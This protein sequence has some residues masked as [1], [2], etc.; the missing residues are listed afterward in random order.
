[1]IS[2]TVSRLCHRAEDSNKYSFGHVL[3]VGG[4]PGM[5]GAP[6]LSATAAMRIGAGLVTIASSSN[7]I[8]KLEER[9]VEIMTLRIELSE[10]SSVDSLISFIDKRRVNAVVVG[11]GLDA[12]FSDFI[13]SF[14]PRVS[15]AT[16]ID[17]GAI[18]CLNGDLEFLHRIAQKNVALILTPH[19]G[20]YKKL[21]GWNL[22]VEH[23]QRIEEVINFA[24][25]QNI[26]LIAKGAH[27]II[28]YTDGTYYENESGNPSLATA[29]TGDVLDGV[30]AGILAQGF[31]VKEA[32]QAAVYLHGYAGDLAASVKTQAGMIAS[33]VIEF[34][35]NALRDTDV[36]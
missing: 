15:C 8:D 21:T 5:V 20:E 11:P 30:I 7:V 19:D 12:S 3:I 10:S 31:S 14:L 2:D 13:H 27:S 25:E 4:S 28:G 26:T 35:P 23:Q 22:S 36:C 34:L 1:M 9:V 29:G 17:A 24:Q 16:V 6:F 32:T 33:D 18:S